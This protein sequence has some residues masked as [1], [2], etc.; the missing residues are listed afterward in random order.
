MVRFVRDGAARARD[1]TPELLAGGLIGWLVISIT[2]YHDARYTLPCLVYCAGARRRAGSR[3]RAAP[4]RGVAA[5]GLAV[6]AL[7]NTVSVDLGAGG[8]RTIGIPV[9][10]LPLRAR[11]ARRR[12]S[13]QH[14]FI[15]GKPNSA[16]DV[17]AVFRAMRRDGIQFYFDDHPSAIGPSLSGTGVDVLARQAGLRVVAGNNPLNLGSDGVILYANHL[18]PSSPPTVHAA[19]LRRRAVHEPRCPDRCVPAA[20][21]LLPARL[22]ALT[23]GSASS[24]TACSRTPSAA[25]S[26]GTA[27][28]PS[29]WPPTA[30]R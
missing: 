11:R 9:A 12:C 26:A 17:L 29:G 23:C 2:T 3:A 21:A 18:V 19:R 13:T 25:P 16:P 10:W 28:S 24:T 15:T 30:T 8:T 5:G 22:P 20:A 14:G 4:W 6:V 1:V 7:L 27:T